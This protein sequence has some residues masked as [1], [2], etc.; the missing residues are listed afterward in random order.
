MRIRSFSPKSQ[1][2]EKNPPVAE[3]KV[4]SPQDAAR[5][6]PF[7]TADPATHFAPPP[8]PS[9]PVGPASGLPPGCELRIDVAVVFPQLGELISSS[10]MIWSSTQFPMLPEDD[11]Q[12]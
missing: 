12:Q 9:A 1:Y 3:G 6:A 2:A 5:A 4:N 10:S 7:V 8:A 11:A